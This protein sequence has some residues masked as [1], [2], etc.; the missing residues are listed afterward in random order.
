MG[1]T[2][3][4]QMSRFH[5]V[6]IKAR[7]NEQILSVFVYLVPF[8]S[9]TVEEAGCRLDPGSYEMKNWRNFLGRSARQRKFH[10]LINESRL[11]SRN[12]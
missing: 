3:T 1:K 4:R 10:Y 5:L 9:S 11:E 2:C 6:C 7:N 8:M 12:L